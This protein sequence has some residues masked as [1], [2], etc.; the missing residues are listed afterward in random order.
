[1]DGWSEF[2]KANAADASVRID[3]LAAETPYT[4]RLV[5][6]SG[7]APE[8]SELFS[9]TTGPPVE[10]CRSGAPYLCLLDGRFEVRAH[11]SN[12]DRSGDFG[13]GTA[14]PVDSS[15]ESGLFRF[16]DRENVELILK[17]LDGREV[18]GNHWVFF[19]ALSDVEYWVTV[20]DT[21][22]GRRLTYYNPPKRICGQGDTQS[23]GA[24]SAASASAFSA[25]PTVTGSIEPGRTDAILPSAVVAGT[26]AARF[27]NVQVVPLDWGAAP[28]VSGPAVANGN[29][30]PGDGRLCLLG[31][32]FSIEVEFIDPKDGAAKVGQVLPSLT[33]A[34][35]GFF[36]FFSSGNI[37][38]AAKVLD[39]RGLN[40]KFWF[41]YGGLSDVE[42]AIRVTDTA[43]GESRIYRNPRGSVCGG[44]DTSALG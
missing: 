10:A 5:A 36:W 16:F 14:V 30:L 9:L 35:T 39:G 27:G 23:F 29:C 20:E 34:S 33:T 28:E 1:M 43:T 25:A 15:D 11:W 3:G 4:F 12:P 22:S 41:L 8:Y 17:V 31:D 13:K 38:L 18:N 19:G 24:A 7:G 2:A 6:V 26:S 32:R 37:E 42:F 44:I 40:G 21:E